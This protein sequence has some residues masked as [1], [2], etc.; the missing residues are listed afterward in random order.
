M[1][2]FKVFLCG[3]FMSLAIYGIAHADIVSLGTN[4]VAG[5]ADV[6][7]HLNNDRTSLTNGVNAVRGAYAGS[8]QSSGQVKAAT[9]GQENMADD[10]NPRIRTYEGAS[11]EKV[12]GMLP[13]TTSGTLTGSVPL[14][15][16]YPRGYRVEKTSGTAHNFTASQWTWVDI[17]QD[18]TFTYVSQ[19]I[20]TSTPAI[21]ANSLRLA[22]VSTDTTQIGY[23]RDLRITSC[24][25]TPFSNF[26][27]AEGDTSLS[28]IFVH[29]NGGI[30]NGLNIISYDD[31]SIKV[32]PGA[33]YIS[34]KYKSLDTAL[35]VP[36]NSAGNSITG[37]SG[38]DTGSVGANTTYYLYATADI[39]A[40]KPVV[41][42]FSS[43]ASVPSGP[44]RY[45]KIGEVMTDPS[46]RLTR[47]TSTDTTSITY[48]GKIR[49]IKKFQTG[50]FAT[51]TTV[52]PY[53]DTIP[54]NAEGDQ[55]MSLAITP[56]SAS[57]RL[58]IDVVFSV[59]NSAGLNNCVAL[60]QDSISPALA[61]NVAYPPN[62]NYI[63]N[64][65]LTHYMVAGTT[66]AT[67]FKVRAG[68]HTAGTM[69]FNGSTAARIFGGVMASSLTITEY[70]G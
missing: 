43:N 15:V 65:K 34:G 22:L 61:A 55:Y 42:I 39:D 66:S 54:T 13:L 47:T 70:E 2:K 26:A 21:T 16:A 41:G 36:I 27:D 3:F 67:T 62:A 20:G 19:N 25:N 32:Q 30:M 9:I 17:A 6:V 63:T 35:I 53:D 45:R 1:S 51:G 28:G 52:M 60:F 40:T 7:T 23:V 24:A 5:E 37:V 14:G 68:P 48:S 12:S 57:N 31:N 18:G 10:A 8:V 59:S 49:Q 69:Y 46:S 4:F 64:I 38:L 44:T 50:D 11:C 33:A 29:A 56:V 58:K